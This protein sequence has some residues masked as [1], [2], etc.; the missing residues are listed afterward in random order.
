MRN[1]TYRAMGIY[2]TNNDVTIGASSHPYLN[3]VLNRVGFMEWE[4]DYSND[5]ISTQKFSFKSYYDIANT[6]S[7]VTMTLGNEVTSY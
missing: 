7:G 2:L 1:G 6:S 3:I 5:D 4:P